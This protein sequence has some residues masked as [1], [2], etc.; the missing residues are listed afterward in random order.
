MRILVA[1]EESQATTKRAI[2]NEVTEDTAIQG[3][4]IEHIWDLT[5]VEQKSDTMFY[6]RE[7]KFAPLGINSI[8][9][10]KCRQLLW[11]FDREKDVDT[12]IHATNLN[13]SPQTP[14]TAAMAE[15]Y[16]YRNIQVAGGTTVLSMNKKELPLA[17]TLHGAEYDV[18]VG[19]GFNV[20]I[21][22]RVDELLALNPRSFKIERDITL[23]HR[24]KKNTPDMLREFHSIGA[25]QVKNIPD[26]IEDLIIPFGSST[27][28]CSILF[29]LRRDR[30]KSLKRIHLINVGVDKRLYMFERLRLMG[31]DK[32]SDYE[33]IYKDTKLPYS[34]V[35]KGV[36]IDDITFHMRYEA[37]AYKYLLENNPELIKPTSLF[38]VIG[39]YPD[40]ETTARNLGREIPTAINPCK[41]DK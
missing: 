6:K 2:L 14:M 31:A 3:R 28:A 34:K 29:G 8:N 7:D 10:S 37:K 40:T 16:G 4:W 13:S 25:E 22:K 30:P 5:P 20:V 15:H 1:C 41:I 32:L 19:S 38:W 27:S 21:Q 17:A 36:R 23:D 18:T 33:I 12:V 11:L 26:H 39:S 35:I 24:L 9:G